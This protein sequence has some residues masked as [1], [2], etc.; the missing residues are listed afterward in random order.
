MSESVRVMMPDGS[1]RV[2]EMV[3]AAFG[4]STT[5]QAKVAVAGTAVK[6]IVPDG[7]RY[8]EIKAG[9]QNTGV[10][11]VGSVVGVTTTRDG[12]GNGYELNS[13]EIVVVEGANIWINS[14]TINSYVTFKAV[15]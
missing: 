4:V 12:T 14:S 15:V 3:V 13:G 8:V 6:L 7:T 11:L 5:G 1:V 2:L 10:V 9:L